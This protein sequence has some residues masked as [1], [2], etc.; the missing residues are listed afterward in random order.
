MDVL[1]LSDVV[2]YSFCSDFASHCGCFTYFYVSEVVLC[3]SVSILVLC[4]VVLCI[5]SVI[6]APL[7][8]CLASLSG[9]LDQEPSVSAS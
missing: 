6:F 3:L 8:G 4:E 5:F 1:W 7:S 2:L 9:Y